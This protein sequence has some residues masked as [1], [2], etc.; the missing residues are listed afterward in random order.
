MNGGAANTQQAQWAQ[1]YVRH[2]LFPVLSDRDQRP[3][4]LMTQIEVLFRGADIDMQSTGDLHWNSWHSWLSW[5]SWNSWNSWHS[6]N[7]VTIPPEG[8]ARE[9]TPSAKG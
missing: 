8:A 4:H 1:P 3:N 9:A 7:S 2:G 5:Q 6:W